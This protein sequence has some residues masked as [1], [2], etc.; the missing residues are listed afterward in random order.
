MD[1]QGTNKLNNAKISN[2]KCDKCGTEFHMKPSR[3]NRTKFHYCSIE[4]TSAHSPARTADKLEI[5]LGIPNLKDYLFEKYINELKT[6]REIAL[7]IYSNKN[8]YNCVIKLLN[9]FNVPIRHGSEAIKTQFIGE[10]G[11][12]R[13]DEISKYI[14]S[15]GGFGSKGARDKLI[16]NMQ[17]DEYKEKCRI[18]KLGELNGMFGV[19]G[20][21]NPLWNPNKTREQR[22]TDRKLFETREWR[23]QIFERDNYT[24]QITNERKG[25]YL[26]AHHLNSYNSDIENRFNIDNGITILENVHKLFHHYYGYGNNTKEQFNEFTLRFNKHEFDKVI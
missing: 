3:I 11:E 24:C 23:N 1:G 2:T 12:K 13:S 19:R 6:S 25:K 22:Q 10:K 21:D 15:G 17:T 8:N 16:E 7:L 4:C 9:Y 20:E 5:K 18:A 14:L 26:V